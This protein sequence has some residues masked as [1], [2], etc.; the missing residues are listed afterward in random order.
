M[1]F[2]DR[3][4]LDDVCR[5]APAIQNDPLFPEGVNVGVAEIV[6]AQTIRLAVWE[7]PRIWTKACGTGAFVAAAVT[8]DNSSI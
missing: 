1:F 7:C 2:V 6:D 5:F 4:L 3:L 8:P